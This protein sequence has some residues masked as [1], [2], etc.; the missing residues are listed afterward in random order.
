MIS[1]VYYANSFGYNEH[2]KLENNAKITHQSTP[3]HDL[4]MHF[5]L[6]CATNMSLL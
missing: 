4:L 5:A 3:K 6:L 1:M 2:V